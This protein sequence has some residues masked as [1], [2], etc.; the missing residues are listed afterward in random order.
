MAEFI[1]HTEYGWANYSVRLV[2]PII[3][4]EHSFAMQSWCIDVL[5]DRWATTPPGVDSQEWYFVTEQ[6]ALLFRLRF[7]PF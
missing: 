2:V 6:D 1:D 5:G 7:G 3:S 4:L